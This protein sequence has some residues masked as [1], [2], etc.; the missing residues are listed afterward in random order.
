MNG[1]VTDDKLRSRQFITRTPPRITPKT[2]IIA[3][4]HPTSISADP[5]D[6]GWFISDF[7]AFNYLLYGQGQSQVWLTAAR[8][9]ALLEKYGN[10]LHGNPFQ[11]R[12][13]VLSKELLESNELT[14]VTYVRP[15]HIIQRLLDE[16]KLATEQAKRD[17]GSV[18]L[19]VF[20]HGNNSTSL[21]LDGT[22]KTELTITRLQGVLEPYVPVCLLT[23]ACYSGGWSVSKDINISTMT[24][25]LESD[26]SLSWPRST[27]MGRAAGSV[28]AASVISALART[29]DKF[30]QD[31]NEAMSVK[32]LSPHN[33]NDP[34][35]P[36]LNTPLQISTYNSFCRSIWQSC[37]SLYR[38]WQR[39]HNFS[40][41]AQG[42]EW[43][44]PWT[45]MTGM[46]LKEYGARWDK[47]ET[48]PYTGSEEIKS[49][50]DPSP[51]NPYFL[52]TSTLVLA[53]GGHRPSHDCTYDAFV[54][55]F[56]ESLHSNNIKAM[57]QLWRGTCPGDDAYGH[58]PG[59]AYYLEKCME[60]GKATPITV[61]DLEE[62]EDPTPM[63]FY[64]VVEILKYRWNMAALAEDILETL[65]L[66][67][68]ANQSCLMWNRAFWEKECCI[69]YSVSGDDRRRKF[70][71]ILGH[72]SKDTESRPE[73][74]KMIR[75][76]AEQ[77]PIFPRFIHYLAAGITE[78]LYQVPLGVIESQEAVQD[79]AMFLTTAAL[80]RVHEAVLFHQQTAINDPEVRRRGR[81]WALVM[82]Q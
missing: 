28:F 37:Q 43:E 21:G 16:V 38:L 27:R 70:S 48:V 67:H 4:A 45:R 14:E 1:H 75:P 18:L 72:F 68:P 3:A 58:G 80:N 31:D 76:V 33:P 61:Y 34:S 69:K 8:P 30:P 7:Y 29:A 42:D 50:L 53:A 77:G 71:V 55:P 44:E 74:L 36:D 60:T 59:F 57:V 62:D 23:T 22:G 56:L 24:A 49:H 25:A 15:C 26:V 35:S 17:G 13:V 19:M 65:D 78:G 52:G 47:L 82:R 11:D 81:E 2:R 40:F 79:R 6:D 20:C 64:D 51:D 54:G 10:Y 9:E 32:D 41:S 5:R 73:M 66:P 12:K 39:Q 63:M 46:T